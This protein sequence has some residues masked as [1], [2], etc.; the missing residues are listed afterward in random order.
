MLHLFYHCILYLFYF[1][2]IIY[3]IIII[4]LYYLY[5]YLFI[6]LV[7]LICCFQWSI[8][9]KVFPLIIMYNRRDNKHLEG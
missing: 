7:F 6:I 8:P 2:I 9:D 1:Y 3:I 5:F 4:I